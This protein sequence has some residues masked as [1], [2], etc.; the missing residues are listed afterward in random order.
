M[1][2]HARTQCSS[3]VVCN[4]ILARSFFTEEKYAKTDI[5]LSIL[6][7]E[8]HHH[9]KNIWSEQIP[10]THLSMRNGTLWQTACSFQQMQ[11][12]QLCGY[13]KESP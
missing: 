5:R 11:N 10:L 6:L 9:N 8:Q 2:M 3:L 4:N 7:H 13:K 1:H 12:I